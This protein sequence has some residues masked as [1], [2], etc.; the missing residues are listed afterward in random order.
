MSLWR[1]IKKKFT[2]Y[3]L[4]NLHGLQFLVPINDNLYDK[5]I[6]QVNKNQ[7][8]IKNSEVTMD[9][10]PIDIYAEILRVIKKKDE[11]L[12]V[13]D[14]GS[15]VGDFGIRLAKQGKDL[16]MSIEVHCVDPT[17][18]ASKIPR[19][20]KMNGVAELV[21]WVSKPISFSG[22]LVNFRTNNGHTDSAHISESGTF[23]DIKF[24]TQE[25]ESI[26]LNDLRSTLKINSLKLFKFDLEGIDA[27][28][29]HNSREFVNDIVIFEFAPSRPEWKLWHEKQ[30]YTGWLNTHFLFDIGYAPNPDRFSR[31]AKEFIIFSESINKRPYGY[32]DIIAI[33]KINSWMLEALTMDVKPPE[34]FSYNLD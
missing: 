19:N 21:N 7:K 13:V 29:L 18:P 6:N 24:K 23:A 9:P 32:T 15:W 2:G 1:R 30:A 4:V 34:N 27:D 26:T 31:V 14:L 3:D 28:F 33:P 8:S 17:H 11:S 22:G 20:A 5:F 16:Q 12:E 25:F 10:L